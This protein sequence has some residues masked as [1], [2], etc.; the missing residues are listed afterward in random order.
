M[1]FMALLLAS[2]LA[3][4]VHAADGSALTS[5]ELR[6]RVAEINAAQN[7]V[8]MRGSTAADVDRLFA[9]YADDFTYVHEAYGG[10]YTRQQLYENTL[11][12]LEAGRY[13]LD[14]DRYTILR[15]IA[16]RNAIAVER[17]ER[18]GAIHL[19]VF[20]FAGTKVSRIV[21]YWK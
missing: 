15:T 12:N 1:R 19:T 8:T 10:T 5:V 13:T 11:R 20:E 4:S 3:L 16:G 14:E 21:E 9:N 7:A 6:N 17:R 2:F 18:G